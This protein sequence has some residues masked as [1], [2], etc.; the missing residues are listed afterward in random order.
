[1]VLPDLFLMPSWSIHFQLVILVWNEVLI[2]FICF[3]WCLYDILNRLFGLNTLIA[4]IQVVWWSIRCHFHLWYWRNNSWHY[5]S[6]GV[7]NIE[8][9]NIPVNILIASLVM[10]C[11]GVV[12]NRVNLVL[13]DII[14]VY[15]G[16]INNLRNWWLWVVGVDS[17]LVDHILGR[18]L[19]INIYHRDKLSFS[20]ALGLLPFHILNHRLIID[21][22]ISIV[23]IVWGN[24]WDGWCLYLLLLVIKVYLV[25]LYLLIR[26]WNKV[27]LL[28]IGW[29]GCFN[30]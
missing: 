12:N 16:A 7:W 15:F 14:I 21:F 17:I 11:N 2:I 5:I 9:I 30:K 23:H 10:A 25:N 27:S 1:M 18:I 13:I 22:I 19:N 26:I 4:Y 28:G 6:L 8:I 3:Q 24:G 29:L 20:C